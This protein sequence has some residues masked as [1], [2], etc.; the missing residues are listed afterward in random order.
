MRSRRGIIYLLHI[1]P[2]YKHAAHYVGF[3]ESADA[4]A[5]LRRHEDGH[6]A[7]LCR[8]AVAA[9]CTLHLV[10]VWSG[11][12]QLERRTKRRA[13]HDRWCPMCCRARGMVPRVEL[14]RSVKRKGAKRAVWG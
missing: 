7:N 4:L 12:R 3:T 1:E 5:R 9:G 2:P 10:R 6:G 13:H 14:F 11:N 8:V